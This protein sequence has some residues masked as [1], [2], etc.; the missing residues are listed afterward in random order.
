MKNNLC[1]CI[2]KI[3]ANLSKMKLLVIL[4]IV[5]SCTYPTFPKWTRECNGKVCRFTY[6]K[7]STIRYFPVVAEY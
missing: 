4:L 7:L 2:K 5:S 3:G 6:T 1:D